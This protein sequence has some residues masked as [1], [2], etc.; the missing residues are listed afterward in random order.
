MIEN[1]SQVD[2]KICILKNETGY[3]AS[4]MSLNFYMWYIKSFLSWMWKLN[5]HFL[6]KQFQWKEAPLSR[7]KR[8]AIQ[9]VCI[10]LLHIS[11]QWPVC[12]STLQWN[13]KYEIFQQLTKRTIASSR[14]WCWF[15]ILSNSSIQQQPWSA[16]TRA[17]ASNA[18]SLPL[19][20]SLHRVTCHLQE[21]YF[22]ITFTIKL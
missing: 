15:P 17:P 4:P 19:L 20:P 10:T 1:T 14:A 7:I 9:M 6:I 3:T 11:K 16:R 5:S 22:H 8:G 18:W 12:C 21:E 2:I 13:Y